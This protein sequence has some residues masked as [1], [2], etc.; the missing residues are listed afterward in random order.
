MVLDASGNAAFLV[1]ENLEN[2]TDY[3]FEKPDFSFVQLQTNLVARWEYI[4]CSDPFFVWVRG[5][6]GLQN[7][8]NFLIDGVRTQVFDIPANDIFLIRAIYRFLQ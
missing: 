4:P 7:F 2:I 3:S 1:D 8:K 6:N 5:A